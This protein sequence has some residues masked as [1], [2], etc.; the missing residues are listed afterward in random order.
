MLLAEWQLRNTLCPGPPNQLYKHVWLL[1]DPCLPTLDR[2]R[3]GT[4]A[5]GPLCSAPELGSGQI[6]LPTP[7]FSKA[8][9]VCKM[10]APSLGSH[11]SSSGR[12]R[13]VSPNALA[14]EHTS[15]ECTSCISKCLI[16]LREVCCTP[17][18]QN[19]STAK[20]FYSAQYMHHAAPRCGDAN[21]ATGE[22]GRV[23][24]FA[25]SWTTARCTNSNYHI[26]AQLGLWYLAVCCR[27]GWDGEYRSLWSMFW[28]PSMS[29][30]LGRKMWLEFIN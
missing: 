13:K 15:L 5:R 23:E 30:I 17:L 10:P 3:W 7:A 21:P 19:T 20:K 11:P 22:G 14:G 24:H 6:F 18:M 27:V 9:A 26:S 16:A 29:R 2:V 4:K 8:F 12:C 28:T 1:C 25:A